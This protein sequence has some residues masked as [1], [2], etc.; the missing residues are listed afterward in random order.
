[1]EKLIHKHQNYL[2]TL[3]ALIRSIKNFSRDDIDEDLRL[4]LVASVIKHF[5]MCYEASWKFLKLY[6]EVRYKQITNS[7]RELFRQCFIF[8]IFDEQTTKEFLKIC[9]AR[10]TTTHTYDEEK[11]QEICDRIDHYYQTFNKINC[12]SLE[13]DDEI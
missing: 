9:D 2:R 12:I 11:A 6:L 10:N 8:N 13:I 4:D 5:E 1:M 7:P 3:N